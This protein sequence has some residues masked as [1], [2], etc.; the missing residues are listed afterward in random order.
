MLLP[1][2]C[3]LFGICGQ[4]LT[5]SETYDGNNI[6]LI[7]DC[8]SKLQHRGQDSYGYTYD[9]LTYHQVGLVDISKLSQSLNILQNFTLIGHLRYVTSGKSSKDDNANIQPFSGKILKHV[10]L[11]PKP[12]AFHYNIDI[13][14]NG[15]IKNT[16]SLH[17]ILIQLNPTISTGELDELKERNHDTYY[18]LKILESLPG[19]YKVFQAED[20]SSYYQADL[21]QRLIQLINLVPGVYCLLVKFEN[22]IY[23]IRD[24]YGVRPLCLGTVNINNKIQH[25][26]ASESV[27]F[28]ANSVLV[29]DVN[30]GEI[31]KITT[32][33]F[34][35]IYQIK[36]VIL[37][38][39]LFEYIYF[40]RPE[41][42]A[43]GL[44][45]TDIRHNYGKLLAEKEINTLNTTI[46][47]DEY[48]IINEPKNICILHPV[49]YEKKGDYLVVGSPSSGIVSGEGYA[50]RMGLQ[51]KQI[52]LK[53]KKIRSF[54]LSN[55]AAR[56]KACYEKFKFQKEEIEGKKIILVDDS[57]V[58]GNTTRIMIQV[59]KELGAIEI[60]IRIASPPI[61]HACYFGI[62]IPDDKELIAVQHNLHSVT[63]II[64]ADSLVYLDLSDVK[65]VH[66]NK[67]CHG[68]FS[69]EYETGLM[70]W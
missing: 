52:I 7:Y 15:N 9:N 12:K 66:G 18:I 17:D 64:G 55:D 68:C 36:D 57:L 27:A 33:G 60:H 63:C 11:K 50:E 61:K 41:T 67:I 3:G 16:H 21:E 23:V 56:R 26:V 46:A 6:K 4:S 19:N 2:E 10:E 59:L 34:K 62:D 51:Y 53:Q 65:N 45:I 28:P 14:H 48:P 24:R 43:N 40:L 29:R 44:K 47:I 31:V 30:P 38:H 49:D 39:C 37:K 70:D 32:E 1:I 42:Q 25:M 8:M 69:G 20:T 5:T 54:I 35:S 13:A 22:I 58:R